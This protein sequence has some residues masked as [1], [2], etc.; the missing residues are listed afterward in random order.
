MTWLG[1]WPGL[2]H[3]LTWYMAWLGTCPDLVHD[4][5]WYIQ[6]KVAWLI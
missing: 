3:G 5:A 1:T 4:L 2:V 6:L